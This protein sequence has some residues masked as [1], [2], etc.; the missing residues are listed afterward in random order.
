MT[1]PGATFPG[2]GRPIIRARGLMESAWHLAA[3]P[4]PKDRPTV[5]IERLSVKNWRNFKSAE[6]DIG[7]R[8]F[9]VGPNA[10]GKS[11]L[12]DAL[13]FLH[14]VAER[15]LRHAVESR[16]GLKL[17]RCL[18]A[19]NFNKG[20]VGLK[21]TLRDTENIQWI[22]KLHFTREREGEHRTIV[23]KEV[24]TRKGE[25]IVK[26]PNEAD[27]NDKELL[28]QT[29]LEQVSS[30]K[31][32][33]SVSEILGRVRYIH[34]VPQIIKHYKSRQD[35]TEDP[36]GSGFLTKLA[37]TDK[38]T[39][40]SR[41]KEIAK[42]LRIAIPQ[43]KELSFSPDKAGNPHLQAGYDHWRPRLA[44]LDE[45]EFSDGTLRLIG[46]LWL[47]EEATGSGRVVLLEE[48]ELSLHA[49]IV[50]Q[51][52]TILYQ[53]TKSCGSQVILSTHSGEMLQ[54][55]GLGIDEVVILQPGSEGTT[56]TSVAKKVDIEVFRTADM[57]IDE[58]VEPLTEPLEV[59]QL[60]RL[61]Q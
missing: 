9:L 47:L 46:M 16:G 18:S 51:L 14:D 30:N 2:R 1:P 28:T 7:R 39:R 35:G 57:N 26:R 31:D 52:P 61:S 40:D 11:N 6:I 23:D 8:L 33:R 20:R 37:K 10:S 43:I 36:F 3:P 41:L 22:Y 13:R 15:G 19:Q 44:R 32:F 24:V 58:I 49:S 55:P 50:R 17:V 12:L 34:L 42:T 60:S 29:A 54:D 4:R 48:P 38:D 27:H 56:V 25:T 21:V 5:R 45:R 53:M 59:W